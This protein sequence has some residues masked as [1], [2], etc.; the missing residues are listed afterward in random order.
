MMNHE[1]PPNWVRGRADCNI[2]MK[3]EALAQI[4]ERDVTEF[5]GLYERHRQGRTCQVQA[6]T[7]GCRPQFRVELD[8][9]VA[10]PPNVLFSLGPTAIRVNGGGVQFYIRPRWDGQ[11]CRMYLND[12]EAI[13]L[14]EISQTALENLFFGSVTVS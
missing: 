10:N 9:D 7:E 14:W 2:D 1:S 13:E 5:N 3:F 11:R 6:S 4:V 8:A 12:K